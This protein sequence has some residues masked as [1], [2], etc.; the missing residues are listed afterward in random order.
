MIAIPE[1]SLLEPMVLKGVVE[2]LMTPPELVLSNR[3]GSA[4][5]PYPVAIWDVIR[6]SRSVA[7]PNVP[8]SEAHIIPRL[9][10]SQE[11]AAFIYLREKKIFEPTTI[12][13]IRT[14]GQLAATNAEAAVLREIND[15]NQRFANFVEYCAWKALQGQIVLDYVDVQANIDYKFPDSHKVTPAVAWATATVPQMIADVRTWKR[16]VQRD[17][18]VPV[19]EVFT[20]ENT[21]AQVFDAFARDSNAAGLMSD[22]MR[23]EYY[24]SGM[25]PGFLGLNWII[26]ESIYEDDAGTETRFLPDGLMI[27]ANLEDNRPMELLEGPSADDDAPDGHTGKFSKTWKEEDPSHRQFLLEY[28]FLPVIYR[29]E[30]IL[31]A[32]VGVPS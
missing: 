28:N 20:T 21:M 3:L 7:K 15:L 6:G 31:V 10:R 13:W 11:S 17:G 25:L 8:N 19:R 26:M 18:Q 2:K 24:S 27:F 9:G 1:I 22:R 23:D 32:S 29:P 4:P 12:H 14:P 5:W 30:Q 16:Q